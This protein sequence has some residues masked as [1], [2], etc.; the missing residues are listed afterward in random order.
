MTISIE[1]NI[2]YLGD[3]VFNNCTSIKSVK[4]GYIDDWSGS[5]HS[6]MFTGCDKLRTIELSNDNPIQLVTFEGN[7]F[8]FNNMWTIQEEAEKLRI[9][10]PDGAAEKYMLEWRYCVCGF[11]G[12]YTGSPYIDMWNSIQSELIDW[13]NFIL[14]KDSEVDDELKKR[15]L[16]SENYLRSILGMEKTDNPSRLYPFRLSEGYLTLAGVPS[17]IKQ[18]DFTTEDCG[19]PSG[20]FFD[21][22]GKDAFA[23]ANGLEKIIIADNLVGIYSGAFS[24]ASDNADKLTIEFRSEIPVQLICD[25]NSTRFD[26]GIDT[27][28]IIIIVPKGTKDTYVTE[29]SSY[30]D[31]EKLDGMIIEKEQQSE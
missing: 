19:L 4:L 12:I 30:I 28:K 1:G 25:K 15:L 17:D 2:Y 14:P 9:T 31:K 22:I 5:L 8:Q 11:T 21:Y 27:G 13:D 24:G 10:V 16:V 26:F 6:G 23:G 20:W 29:W 7:V 18:L 3:M